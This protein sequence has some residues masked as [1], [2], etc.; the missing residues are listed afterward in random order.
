MQVKKKQLELDMEHWFQVRKGVC[1]GCLL[2]PCLF[3]LH[4]EYI[5][6]N[7]G[8]DEAQAVFKTAGRDINNHKYVDDITFMEES[9][10]VLKRLDRGERGECKS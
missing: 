5:M 6:R 4:A 3:N 8:L 9:K 7:A 2:S 10:E 1:Q